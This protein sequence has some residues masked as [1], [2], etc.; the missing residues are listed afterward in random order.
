MQ[1]D[2]EE[3]LKQEKHI[4]VRLKELQVES[5]VENAIPRLQRAKGNEKCLNWETL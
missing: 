5:Q 1:E 3:A 2:G 4:G